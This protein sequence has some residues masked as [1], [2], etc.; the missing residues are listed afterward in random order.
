MVTGRFSAWAS[1]ASTLLL[2][3]SLAVHA[4]SER[5]T[6]VRAAFLFRLA[7][8]VEWTPDA[9][10]EP[11]SPLRLCIGHGAFADELARTLFEQTRGRTVQGRAL[12]IHGL[13]RGEA[14]GGCHIVYLADGTDAIAGSDYSLVVVESLPQLEHEGALALVRE[15]GGNEARLVFYGVRD[16]LEQGQFTVSSKLLQLL[17]FH[18]PRG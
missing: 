15:H 13:A 2:V 5:E 18:Q 17:R 16:R 14:A 3:C 11:A 7:F 9:F 8:F 1:A 6:T 12:D 10:P 4:D